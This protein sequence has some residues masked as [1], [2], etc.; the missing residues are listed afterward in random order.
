MSSKVIVVDEN[1]EIIG[2]KDSES[3]EQDDIYRAS[4]LMITNSKGQVLLAK[5]ALNKKHNPGC[6]GPAV[7]GTIEEGEDYYSNIVKEAEEEL[8]L[9]NIKPLM[10]PK[11]RMGGEYNYFVQWYF[12][13]LDKPL[14]EF[15]VNQEEVVE[16]RWVDKDKLWKEVKENPEQ[17]TPS[18]KDWKVLLQ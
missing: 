1:D 9:K 17:F 8:G 13:K 16:I 5:R 7:A 11:I 18:A 10:G 2:L 15:R 4:A 3:L 12:L 6:W 14:D